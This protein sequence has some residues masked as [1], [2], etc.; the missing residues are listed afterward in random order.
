MLVLVLA[1]VTL[2]VVG[3]RDVPI[4]RDLRGG[5]LPVVGPVENAVGT[6]TRP[7]RNAWHGITDYEDLQRENERLQEQL[8]EA[9]ST[10][11]GRVRRRAAARRPVG[12][13]EPAVRRRRPQGDSPGRGRSPLELLVRHRDRQGQPP[14]GW[15]WACRSRPAVGSSGASTRSPSTGPAVEVVTDP[16]FRVGVRLATTGALGTASGQGRGEAL[17]VDSSISPSTAVDAGPAWSP[18]ASTAAPPPGIPVGTVS[19]T[20]A[21]PGRAVARARRR[22]ARRRRPALVRDRAPVAGGVNGAPAPLGAGPG[23]VVV[24]VAA[25]AADLAGQRPADR[26]RHGGSRARRRRGRRHHRRRRPRRHVRVRGG[27]VYDLLST[28]PSG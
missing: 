18:A 10:A 13:A 23:R 20:P 11:I 27:L 19:D 5:R 25:R 3:L 15:R 6:V 28:A 22:P 14:T 26:R 21:G 24:V 17:T 7:V 9:E 16:E 2:V 4:V 8:A 1:S 12:L